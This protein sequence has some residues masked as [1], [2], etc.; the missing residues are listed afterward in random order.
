[1]RF[2]QAYAHPLCSP[3][4]A[5]I[6]TGQE[7]SRHGIMS[8][9][10]HLEPEP[11]G[12][13]VYQENPSPDQPYLL[14]KSR[15]YLDP[16]A[17]TLAE[18]LQAAGY[19]TAHLGKWHLGLTEP[20]WPEAHGFETTFHCAPDPG[21]PGS[22][23]FSPHG[24]HPDGHPSGK[25][26]VG[27]VTDGPEG[28]HIADRLAREAMNFITAHQ[29]E[30]FFLNLCQYSVHGPWEAKGDYIEHFK[31]KKDPTGRHTN[32]VMAAMLKSMDDSLGQV[33]KALDHLDL[34][35]DTIVVFFSDNGGNVK[36]WSTEGEQN[37]YLKLPKHHLHHM[38]KASPPSHG[39]SLSRA[40]RAPATDQQCPAQDGQG[41]SLRRRRTRSA[42][43]ALAGQDQGRRNQRGDH[44]QH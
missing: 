24:V 33:L 7:E 18:A 31:Q 29:D 40:R 23:Y 28:E 36:S 12:P 8:A 38:V 6:M 1:M 26:R 21:P 9:H 14:P 11:W 10:G 15:R 34:A 41:L 39:E 30:P 3:S 17:I 44:Q 19:R 35:D 43:G 2:T 32:P 37:R 25:H 27:N 42:D 22:T 20:H 4:R 13:Q 5:S 16:E